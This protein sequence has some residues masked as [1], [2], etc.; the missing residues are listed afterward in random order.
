MERDR[1]LGIATDSTKLFEHFAIEKDDF[2]SNYISDNF[3]EKESMIRY[4]EKAIAK[5]KK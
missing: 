1:L 4:I 2:L 3:S 5:Y